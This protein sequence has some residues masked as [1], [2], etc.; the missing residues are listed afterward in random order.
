MSRSRVIRRTL[1]RHDQRRVTGDGEVHRHW[2]CGIPHL[3]RHSVVIDQKRNLLSQIIG[4]QI[5]PGDRGCV[6]TGFGHMPIAQSA[7]GGG[8]ACRGDSYLGIKSANPRLGHPFGQNFAELG[9]KKP[10]R[11][12]VKLDQ[13][14][15]GAVCIRKCLVVDPFG[16]EDPGRMLAVHSFTCKSLRSL[17]PLMRHPQTDRS[18]RTGRHRQG[19]DSRF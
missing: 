12:V 15:N 2:G 10:G 3:N 18:V 13:A 7:V 14:L 6:P 19:P 1:P 5:G 4:K 17:T 8:K 9:A 16:G 11:G